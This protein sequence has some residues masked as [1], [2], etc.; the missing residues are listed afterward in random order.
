MGPGRDTSRSFGIYD[1]GH[2]VLT[3]DSTR[4][5]SSDE[6]FPAQQEKDEARFDDY[7]AVPSIGSY[8]DDDDDGAAEHYAYDAET[9]PLEQHRR[10]SA[11]T[12]TTISSFPASIRPSEND[13]GGQ[14]D[15]RTPCRP[16]PSFRNTSSFRRIQTSS[17]DAFERQH[18]SS[19]QS[20][21]LQRSS[22][23][24]RSTPRSVKRVRT[25]PSPRAGARARRQGGP[26]PE[27]E[28]EGA[29]DEESKEEGEGGGET[30]HEHAL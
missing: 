11:Q 26:G 7:D 1:D 17:P 15:A 3:P 4:H 14:R 18:T 5:P 6:E 20:S 22:P 21:I 9:S 29:A 12:A 10:I 8:N 16:R 2:G 27:E 24:R 13:G 30:R 28:E 19:R 25:C 23:R